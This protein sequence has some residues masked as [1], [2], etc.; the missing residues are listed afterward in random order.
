MVRSMLCV[1]RWHTCITALVCRRGLTRR[2][3]RD[4]RRSWRQRRHSSQSWRRAMQ[5]CQVSWTQVTCN[6]MALQQ[7]Q[8]GIYM[9]FF[10]TDTLSASPKSKHVT[11]GVTRSLKPRA[12]L[13]M[14][15]L[16][17]RA[18]VMQLGLGWMSFAPKSRLWWP[19]QLS[20]LISK[21][22]CRPMKPP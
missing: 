8:P 12:E 11:S 17:Y 2:H 5:P 3:V 21:R 20:W 14:Q 18:L 13:Q 6:Y 10:M 4:G 9:R 7:P 19:P 22:S 15:V 16:L 1:L